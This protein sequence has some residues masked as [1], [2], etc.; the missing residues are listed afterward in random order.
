[1]DVATFLSIKER[2]EELG[3]V[4]DKGV[5]LPRS[6]RLSKCYSR[7]VTPAGPVTLPTLPPHDSPPHLSHHV[8]CLH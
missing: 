2:M 8:V 5:T 1:M 4:T 3:T 7:Y 6:F